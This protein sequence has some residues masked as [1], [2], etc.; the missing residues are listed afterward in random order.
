[1]LRS[2]D[3]GV[4]ANCKD[5]HR[6]RAAYAL[7]LNET[8]AV[9]LSILQCFANVRL[10]GMY[11]DQQPTEVKEARTRFVTL[12]DLAFWLAR[13]CRERGDASPGW[14]APQIKMLTLTANN[15]VERIFCVGFRR[16]KTTPIRMTVQTVTW[17]QQL[18]TYRR[19]CLVR[20]KMG[21]LPHPVPLTATLRH[22]QTLR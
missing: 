3:C 10:H 16:P 12:C 14:P 2:A 4:A 7:C 20:T 1:M 21:A 5:K 6:C 19:R 13:D 22:H 11:D 17:N 18:Q 9:A 8:C 15:C